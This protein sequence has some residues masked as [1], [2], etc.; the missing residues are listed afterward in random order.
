VRLTTR[1]CFSK[2]LD[3]S[4]QNLTRCIQKAGHAVRLCVF[5]EADCKLLVWKNGC[6]KL[7]GFSENCR[8]DKTPG[9]QELSSGSVAKPGH[10]SACN[11]AKAR[12]MSSSSGRVLKASSNA[13]RDSAAL[14]KSSISSRGLPRPLLIASRFLARALSRCSNIA[15][16]SCVD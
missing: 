15:F 5:T 11:F 1:G 10:S 2:K 4:G 3:D 13:R 6:R 12:R 8:K 14:T 16:E 9:L 7:I